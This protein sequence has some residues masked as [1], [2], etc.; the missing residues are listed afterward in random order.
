MPALL[1]LALVLA[2]SCSPARVPVRQDAAPEGG[3]TVRRLGPTRG[4]EGLF[5]IDWVDASF[6]RRRNLPAV[7]PHVARLLP[8]VAKL[9]R[10]EGE[11]TRPEDELLAER[12]AFC[13]LPHRRRFNERRCAAYDERRCAAGECTYTHYGN[14]SGLLV[15]GCALVTAAHCVAG[16]GDDDLA[17]WSVLLLRR[18]RERWSVETRGL[19]GPPKPAKRTW[20]QAWTV[21]Q[22]DPTDHLDAALVPIAGR[23]PDAGPRP[24]AVPATGAPLFILGFPRSGP[25]P[26]L[27]VAAA[28]YEPVFGEPAAS[29]GRVVDDNPADAPLCSTTGR[30]DHWQ[31]HA[32]CEA[33]TGA[34]ESGEPTPTGHITS[35]PFVSNADTINGL[36]GAPVFDAEGRWVGVNVTVTGADPRE[37]YSPAMR[38]I[39]VKAEAVW[40]ALR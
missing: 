33:G 24:H 3:P 19:S 34:D 4:L 26:Q 2:A 40:A 15:P 28:G 25:R 9:V 23:C 11:R 13:A 31:P 32:P 39:H 38:A 10:H 1:T 17:R 30:Q 36:S 12:D 5:P 27:A 8:H 35:S 16:L 22:P 20:D 18:E 37:G 7:A 14:C 29:F 6:L 21:P